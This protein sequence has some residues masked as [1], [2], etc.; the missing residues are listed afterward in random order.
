MKDKWENKKKYNK[1]IIF[2]YLII[3]CEHIKM[4]IL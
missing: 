3:Q 1:I 4:F 2:Y